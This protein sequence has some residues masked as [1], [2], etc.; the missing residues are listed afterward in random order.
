MTVDDRVFSKDNAE[1]R[2]DML[3]KLWPTLNTGGV[4]KITDP[5]FLFS[6]L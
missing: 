5:R 3:K 4:L 2:T 6:M 1:A